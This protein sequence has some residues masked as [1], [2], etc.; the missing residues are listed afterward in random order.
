MIYQNGRHR[1]CIVKADRLKDIQILRFI[2]VNGEELSETDM[3][4]CHDKT[5]V[6][7]TVTGNGATHLV[8]ESLYLLMVTNMTV[9][10]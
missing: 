3:G 9:T 5:A 1:L 7:M 2:L 10:D 6:D 4:S 8:V